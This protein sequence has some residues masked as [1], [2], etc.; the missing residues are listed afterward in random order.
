MPEPTHNRVTIDSVAERAGVSTATVSRVINKTGPVAG[1]TAQRVYAAVAELNYIP[2]MGARALASRHT[3]T[4]GLVFPALS[5]V[6]FFE[7]IR[8]IQET[9]AA[10]GYG[11]LLYTTDLPERVDVLNLPLGEHNTDG[12]IVFTNSLADDALRRLHT[13]GL[14][15][16]LLHRSPPAGLP[17]PCVTFENKD[18]AYAVV[19]H[20]LENG[21]RRI[22]FLAGAPD[23]EDSYWRE[24]GYRLALA[25]Y[26][27]VPDPSLRGE[28]SFE[29]RLAEALVSH[30][31]VEGRQM[32]AI[33]AADDVSAR[34]ALRAVQTAGLVVPDDIAIVGFDDALLSRYLVPPLTTVRAPIEEAGSAAA[35]Q[36]LQLIHGQVAEPLTLL[37]TQ[38]VIRRSCCREHRVDLTEVMPGAEAENLP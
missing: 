31:L 11:L 32:D 20:L 37:P 35:H 27:L 16:V 30:W 2:H 6:F 22:A 21:R 13:H 33:F 28:A 18:G 12:L 14:P 8:G 34:G 36:L 24:L 29:E 9:A 1:A 38:L 7:L 4:I 19:R 25:D 5:D 10:H 15:L 23:N 17:I 26:D 3:D